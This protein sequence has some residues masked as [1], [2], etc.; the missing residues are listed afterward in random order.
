MRR[1]AVLCV[2]ILGAVCAYPKTVRA[3][4]G[5]LYTGGSVALE[6]GQLGYLRQGLEGGEGFGTP[7]ELLPRFGGFA[8]YGLSN[9][10]QLGAAFEYAYRSSTEYPGSIVDGRTGSLFVRY[11]EWSLPVT[12]SY[13]FSRGYSSSLLASLEL[14]VSSVTF[15]DQSFVDPERPD[16]EGNPGA[17]D[18]DLRK[19]SGMGLL[20][21]GR[22][23]WDWRISSWLVFDIGPYLHWRQAAV[24]GGTSGNVHFGLAIRP[25]FIW[26]A[27]PRVF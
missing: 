27:G 6:Y 4:A 19:E 25:A 8:R 9:E 24:D 3:E 16:A 10:V 18:I 21:G 5:E 22:L 7:T 17:I 13:L 14:G 11:A 15:E 23:E 20:V 26:A 2:G 1:I 12:L